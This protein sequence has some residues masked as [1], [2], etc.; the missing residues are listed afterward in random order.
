MNWFS[1]SEVVGFS[2]FLVGGL[3]IVLSNESVGCCWLLLL[4]VVVVGWKE[5]YL[6][7][8]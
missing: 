7:V 4:L 6:I 5:T 3:E 2:W 8:L 1:W